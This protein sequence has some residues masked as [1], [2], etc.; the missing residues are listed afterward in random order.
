MKTKLVA[1]VLILMSGVVLA[2]YPAS[3]AGE[4]NT[5]GDHFDVI[6]SKTQGMA[7]GMMSPFN[8]LEQGMKFEKEDNYYASLNELDKALAL[9]ANFAEAHDY[10]AVV[11]IKLGRFIKALRSVNNALSCNPN[12]AEAFNHRGI[13]HF[14]LQNA[15]EALKDYS[16]AIELKPDYATAYYNRGLLKLSMD[17][18]QGALKDL[19]KARELKCTDAEPVIKEFLADKE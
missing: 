15:D 9:D 3:F 1:S 11:Y 14:Y 12:F 16:R 5:Y 6:A 19:I 18:E 10:K 17:D 8:Y 7:S 13:I 4:D 2:Q